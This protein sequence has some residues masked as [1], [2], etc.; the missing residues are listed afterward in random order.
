MTRSRARIQRKLAGHIGVECAP[1][2]K[3]M[4]CGYQFN[5]TM[6]KHELLICVGNF[7]SEDEARAYAKALIDSGVFVNTRAVS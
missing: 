3:P 1:D 2:A 7:D 5:P 4:V 6:G